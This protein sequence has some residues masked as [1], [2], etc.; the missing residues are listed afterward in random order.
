MLSGDSI[1]GRTIQTRAVG[2]RI[3]LFLKGYRVRFQTVEIGDLDVHLRTLRDLNQYSDDEGSAAQADIPPASWPLF[4]VVWASSRVLANRMLGFDIEGRRILEVG[5]G[6]GLTSLVLKYRNADI[7]AT[8][9][10][11]EVEGFLEFNAGLNDL[12]PIPYFRCDWKDSGDRLGKFDLILGS[13]LVYEPGHAEL[14]SGF[15]DRHA[16]RQCEVVTVGPGRREQARFNHSMIELGYH[17][18]HEAPEDNGDP[19]EPFRG[20]IQRYQRI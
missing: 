5:C 10:H 17:H 4:G 3:E 7:S 2:F 16:E 14:L 20:R 6:I 19:A 9:R 18:W 1:S 12:S 11:P 13:D 8:D 15:I